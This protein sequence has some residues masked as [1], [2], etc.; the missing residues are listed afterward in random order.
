MIDADE[1][2]LRKKLDELS[3]RLRAREDDFRQKGRFSDVQEA[4]LKRI[5][6]RS[7]GLKKKVAEAGE[8]GTTR[9]L[10]QTELLR[11][12]LQLEERLDAEFMQ[13]SSSQ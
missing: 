13:Q 10:M 6:Q 11:D 1:V 8:K 12:W 7:D 2:T 4:F 9:E 3:D 5:R